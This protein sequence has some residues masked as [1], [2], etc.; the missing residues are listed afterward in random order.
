MR[1]I[2]D[3]NGFSS[4]VGESGIEKIK[5]SF[6]E[7]FGLALSTL[8]SMSDKLP[9]DYEKRTKWNLVHD[10]IIA[11]LKNKFDID[12]D[13]EIGKWKGI[14]AI[15]F[16]ETAFCRIKKFRGHTS[17]VSV[18]ATPQQKKF[19]SQYSMD[20][21]PEEPTL[22]TIGYH[23][24]RAETEL[25]SISALCKNANGIIWFQQIDGSGFNQLSIF[26]NPI[27]PVIPLAPSK[28]ATGQS[29]KKKRVK[30][31]IDPKKDTGTQQE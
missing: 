10:A 17:K 23:V 12:G 8:E 2:I 6:F 15:K 11:F 25:L 13:V 19:D 22:I 18:Y 1:A 24:N 3:Y 29:E 14:S 20:G 30:P 5:E 4:T 7:G 31:K 27:A 28:T 9:M 16:G 21:I 26:D